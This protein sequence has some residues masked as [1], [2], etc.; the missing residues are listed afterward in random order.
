MKSFFWNFFHFL[1][2]ILLEFSLTVLGKDNRSSVG[3]NLLRIQ[4]ENATL[5]IP[6]RKLLRG[7]WLLFHSYLVK[8]LKNSTYDGMANKGV[9]ENPEVISFSGR[10]PCGCSGS[11]V[12]FLVFVWR[13][14]GQP[15]Y[16]NSFCLRA[17]FCSV[18]PLRTITVLVP[19]KV[20]VWGIFCY[21]MLTC[22]IC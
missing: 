18:D 6:H 16:D 19:S 2:V 17:C 12:L 13:F 1:M 9:I 4:E 10:L 21:A 8:I 14:L 11:V 3:L 7:M 22:T 5:S 20:H 15:V